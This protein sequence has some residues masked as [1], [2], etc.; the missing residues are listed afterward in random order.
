MDPEYTVLFSNENKAEC[1]S[2]KNKW[3]VV[4]IAVPAVVVVLLLLIF[5]LVGFK[6]YEKGSGGRV[7]KKETKKE[8]LADF[9]IKNFRKFLLSW[10][11]HFRKFL[12]FGNFLL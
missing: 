1:G 4:E 6:K 3:L 11:S 12:Q 8:K 10:R 9:R 2:N 7:K 5:L